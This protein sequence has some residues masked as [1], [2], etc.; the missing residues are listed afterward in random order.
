MSCGLYTDEE[1]IEKLK[2]IDI[3]LDEAVSKTSLDTGQSKHDITIS[4]RTLR[5]QYE[6]YSS[7]LQVQNPELYRC[8]FG[9]S[10]IKSRGYRC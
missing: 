8:T 4:V 5:E 7:M 2:E 1:L 10:V 3:E 9:N 6:K